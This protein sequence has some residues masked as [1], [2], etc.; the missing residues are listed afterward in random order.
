MVRMKGR[1]RRRE[2]RGGRG[3]GGGWDHGAEGV[4]M[5]LILNNNSR[6]IFVIYKK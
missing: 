4:T 5:I 2:R 6:T 3:G 1:E